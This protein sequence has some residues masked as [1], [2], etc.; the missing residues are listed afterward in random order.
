M[1]RRRS[2]LVRGRIVRGVEQ[3]P[4]HAVLA[5]GGLEEGVSSGGGVGP[6][7]EREAKCGKMCHGVDCGDQGG[8]KGVRL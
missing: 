7:A 8:G 2:A 3:G 5:A 4:R 6:E 1:A